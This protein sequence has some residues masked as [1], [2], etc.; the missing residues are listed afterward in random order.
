VNQQLAP[1]FQ[2]GKPITIT[3]IAEAFDKQLSPRTHVVIDLFE[4]LGSTLKTLIFT[5]GALFLVI[6]Y[7]LRPLDYLGSLFGSN[8]TAAKL[9]GITLGFLIV[10]WAIAK[11]RVFA[12]AAAH[13]LL[14]IMQFAEKAALKANVIW[15]AI[16][17]ATLRAYNT[18]LWLTIRGGWAWIAVAIKM[19]AAT[20]MNTIAIWDFNAA[21]YA[22][23][24][25]LIIAAILA[26]TAGLVVLYFRWERFHKWVD[27]T[28]HLMQKFPYLA[29]LIP[30]YGQVIFSILIVEKLYHWFK[31]IYNLLS[32]PLRLKIHMPG[33]LGIGGFL[34]R[35]NPVTAPF[36]WGN[37]GAKALGLP[38][39][40]MGGSIT[41]GGLAMVG[42]G[43]P[44]IVS[45]SAGA[46]VIPLEQSMAPGFQFPSELN[47]KAIL[48]VDG[49]DLAEVVARHR[50]DRQAR[51]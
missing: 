10:L 42:E 41:R 32:H 31:R 29:F 34:A 33:G 25:V 51:R 23:P 8:R 21:L 1:L 4:I 43:G 3:R 38:H 15:T 49:K 47:L 14:L 24:V 17:V 28:Y 5:F 13:E 40:A 46:Q 11:I 9:L 12:L 36:A 30:V 26:L 20:L 44:E 39:L 6:T 2:Q 16:Y 37:L 48:R 18:M 27:R 35:A 22:N 7:V 45:L 50:L 19:R